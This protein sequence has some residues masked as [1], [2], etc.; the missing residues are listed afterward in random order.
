MEQ[1]T[2]H[3][4]RASWEKQT[5]K[6]VFDKDFFSYEV[7]P[8]VIETI[9]KHDIHELRYGVRW[10]SFRLVVGR[11]HQIFIRSIEGKVIKICFRTYFGRKKKEQFALYVEIINKLWEFYFSDLAD[12]LLKEFDKG[13]E[14]L[15][16]DVTLT[17]NHLILNVNQLLNVKRI[18]IP[19][20]DVRTRNYYSYFSIYSEKNPT[21]I[22]R[23][24]D[25]LKDWNTLLLISVVRGILQ[26]NGYEVYDE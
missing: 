6:L 26:H 25:Y 10:I 17:S 13:N 3:I 16:G 18:E 20:E 15:I 7:K 19:W 12:E 24:Y 22:N 2:L 9:Q 14:V 8:G 4:K 11:E 23:G 21:D 1:Q 5:L